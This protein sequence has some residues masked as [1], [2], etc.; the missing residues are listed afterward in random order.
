[1]APDTLQNAWHHFWV[2]NRVE[3]DHHWNLDE[4]NHKRVKAFRDTGGL[5]LRRREE[6]VA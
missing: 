4:I 2:S 5:T 6:I 3:A 1:M